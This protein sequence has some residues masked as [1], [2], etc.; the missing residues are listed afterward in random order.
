MCMTIHDFFPLEATQSSIFEFMGNRNREESS[1]A[2]F[3]FLPFFVL[4]TS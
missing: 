2:S 4:A 3:F 1:L